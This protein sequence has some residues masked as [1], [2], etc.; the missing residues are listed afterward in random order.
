VNT[1]HWSKEFGS[2]IKWFANIWGALSCSSL[3]MTWY[4][5]FNFD[6]ILIRYFTANRNID[7]DIDVSKIVSM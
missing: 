5:D 1:Y 2:W 3:V 7:I 4:Q 6:T